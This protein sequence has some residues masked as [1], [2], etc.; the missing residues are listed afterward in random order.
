VDAVRDDERIVGSVDIGTTKVSAI[1]GERQDAG[2]RVIGVGT[3]PS[4]GLKQGMVVDLDRA[5]KSVERAV[6]DAER[7][8]GV[9]LKKC[10]VG[11][12]GEHIRSMNSRGVVGIPSP[13]HEIAREDVAR[14]LT[15]ARSFSLPSD[16]EILHTL[17]QQYIVDDQPGILEPCG[18]YGSRLEARVHVVTASH[19]ALDNV[20]KTLDN[21]RLEIGELV[22]EPLASAEAVLTNDEKELGVMLLDIGGGTTDVLVYRDGGVAASGVIGLG[23]NNVTADVAYGLRTAMKAAEAIKI[24]HG[25]ALSAMVDP[26]EKIE[27]PGI[28]FR[29]DRQVARQ[30][31]SAIIEPRVTELLSL[32]NEQIGKNELGRVLGAGVVLTGGSSL[33]NGMRELSEQ[34]FDLPVRIGTPVGVGGFPEVIGHPMYATGIG[35]LLYNDASEAGGYTR[36]SSRKGWKQ[37]FNQLRKAIA[38]FI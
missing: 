19:H 7:M 38:S 1:L 20:A 9:R 28:G 6:R 16:R 10:N 34:I 37:S 8:A 14:A 15:A 13:D 36:A 4:D 32:I 17:P 29:D 27:V 33:L 18:M 2:V 3:A 35:L 30:L 26:D 23:G 22:L 5:S 24:E 21:V 11:I 25:C 12:A 31:L